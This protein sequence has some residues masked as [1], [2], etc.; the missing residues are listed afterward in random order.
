MLTRS[1]ADDDYYSVRFAACFALKEFHPRLLEANQKSA[2]T[3]GI[4]HSERKKSVPSPHILTF[5][6]ELK[7]EG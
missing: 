6:P 7:M 2:A 4:E 1:V 5:D 3:S